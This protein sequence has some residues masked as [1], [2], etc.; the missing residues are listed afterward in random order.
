MYTLLYLSH[1]HLDGANGETELGILDYSFLFA[2]ALAM[3][4]R[5]VHELRIY[6]Y[7]HYISR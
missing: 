4:I 5:Y 2:Y 6:T 1:A 3:F 7:T